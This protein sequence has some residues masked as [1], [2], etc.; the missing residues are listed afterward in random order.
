M[1]A[2]AGPGAVKAAG[3]ETDEETG[4]KP[5]GLEA[6]APVTGAWVAAA[7]GVPSIAKFWGGGGRGVC[8]CGVA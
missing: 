8:G 7:N 1:V 3:A 5:P 2:G 6:E 4:A